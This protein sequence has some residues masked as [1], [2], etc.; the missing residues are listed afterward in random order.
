MKLVF[1]QPT[2]SAEAA[3]Q[4]W[5]RRQHEVI[6]PSKGKGSYD[7]KKFNLREMA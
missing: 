6:L 3:I 1:K 7:R 5:Q 2:L 4:L